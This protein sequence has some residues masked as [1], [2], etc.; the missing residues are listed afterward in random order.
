MEVKPLDR[1]VCTVPCAEDCKVS[2]WSAWSE[3]SA[4]CTSGKSICRNMLPRPWLGQIELKTTC[5]AC[6][7]YINLI[8]K[9][10][11]P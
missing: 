2:I 6:T 10:P 8:S 9:S 11:G 4:S 3:C 7:V 1:D 5:T